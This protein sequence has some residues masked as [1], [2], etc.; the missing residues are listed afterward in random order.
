M[1]GQLRMAN[2]PMTRRKTTSLR[3][4]IAARNGDDQTAIIDSKIA[5]PPTEY[6]F[7]GAPPRSMDVPRHIRRSFAEVVESLAARRRRRLRAPS[8]VSRS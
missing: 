1:A 3:G 7:D 6:F 5:S 4:W 2:D 8:R